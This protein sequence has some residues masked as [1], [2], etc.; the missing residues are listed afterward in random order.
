MHLAFIPI[1][2]V[3]RAVSTKNEP[4][5]L[6]KQ[7]EQ[8]ASLLSCEV[9]NGVH[10][11]H[12]EGGECVEAGLGLGLSMDVHKDVPAYAYAVGTLDKHGFA[13]HMPSLAFPHLE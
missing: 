11:C 2:G 4:F 6:V 1:P 12:E 5:F 13:S 7:V 8:G 3:Y 10:R 9:G